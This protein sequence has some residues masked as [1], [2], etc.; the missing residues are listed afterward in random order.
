[1]PEARTLHKLQAQFVKTR[2]IVP[3]ASSLS[4]QISVTDAS[5]SC[6][7]AAWLR[8]N[9]VHSAMAC[10]VDIIKSCEFKMFFLAYAYLKPG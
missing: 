3:Y 7:S 8:L 10:I 2:G 9:P 6:V 1:M 4:R 5:C